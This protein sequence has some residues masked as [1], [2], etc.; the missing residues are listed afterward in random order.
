MT[1]QGRETERRQAE[2]VA[3]EFIEKGLLPE[4]V[5]ND[6]LRCLDSQKP[7]QALETV[8]QHRKDRF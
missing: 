4:S 3:K 6:V 1:H 5:E 2:E 8:L 7:V